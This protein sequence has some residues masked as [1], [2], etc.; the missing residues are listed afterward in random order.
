MPGALFFLL[1]GAVGTGGGDVLLLTD[2]RIVQ[3]HALERAEDGIRVTF[4]SGTVLVPQAIVH[5]ALIEGE[6]DPEPRDEDERQ[7]YAD[8]L[9][10]Y[11]GDWI[12]R[13][14]RDDLVARRAA[15]KKAEIEDNLAHR[16][17]K[18]RRKDESKNFRF[19]YT[20]PQHV[21][22]NYEERM[23]AYY[24]VFAK[25][26]KIRSPKQGKLNVCF[27]SSPK[28]FYRTSGAG[29]GVL[30]YF[31]FVEPYDL[32][33]F[34]DRL[35]ETLTEQVLYHEANH[36]LQKLIDE[37]FKYPHFPGE[38]L[39][40]YYG[41]SLWDSDKRKL[42][43]GL[44]QEGRLAEIQDD[45]AG[46]EW[47]GIQKLLSDDHYEHY[48]WGW[49]L[50]YYL[51]N[52][53]R[54][55]DNFKRFVVG[56]AK[57]KDV[58]RSTFG[59]GLSTV[60]PADLLEAFQKYLRL[61]DEKTRALERDWHR[62]IEEQMLPG[63]STRG[64]EKA[65]FKALSTGRKIRAQ[66]LFQEAVDGGSTNAQLY[67]K[68]AGLLEGDQDEQARAMARRA[69]ELDP[70]TGAYWYTLARLVRSSDKAESERLKALAR[71]VD[72]EFDEG[73]LSFSF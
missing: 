59:M 41:A 72:P 4:D 58:R 67:H 3:E 51:M 36:Y 39:A 32:N 68:Y 37:G 56:L 60:A 46:G 73:A 23:E 11:E 52:E 62:A 64:I 42:T 50:V 8:G 35:D 70:L 30:A 66:R 22:E 57:G 6:P 26:W 28:E 13:R 7:K 47:W 55:A 63:L 49:A 12:P 19:E 33:L 25:D 44:L 5:L 21:F 17:W 65:A 10:P 48:T 43:V 16:E 1:A 69:T 34:Y 40:E 2:G 71:E 45:I 20:V 18:D 29:Y 53:P 27:Y 31:K 54:H 24:Q 15:A 14:R 9:V 61:D 38:S